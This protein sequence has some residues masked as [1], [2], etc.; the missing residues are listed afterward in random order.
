[1]HPAHPAQAT[2]VP[3][4]HTQCGA[5]FPLDFCTYAMLDGDCNPTGN[6]A[7]TRSITITAIN[8]VHI[9]LRDPD[10]IRHF[11]IRIGRL[12]DD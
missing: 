4:F 1:M 3:M 6:L 12:A 9:R 8:G 11:L 10:D 5:G 2:V 7:Q